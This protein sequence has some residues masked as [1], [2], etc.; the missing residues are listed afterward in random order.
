[1][2]GRGNPSIRMP[3]SCDDA[4][5]TH[6]WLVL[7]SVDRRDRMALSATI[8]APRW[9][10]KGSAQAELEP[11]DGSVRL[12]WL[13]LDA[14]TTHGLSRKYTCG[15]DRMLGQPGG[16]LPIELLHPWAR[17]FPTRSRDVVVLLGAGQ[18]AAVR[19]YGPAIRRQQAKRDVPGVE[20]APTL[21]ALGHRT[22]HA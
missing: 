8:P 17:E 6:L 20:M 21:P 4:S 3:E 2:R 5:R 19:Q 1:M 7:S 13:S 22:S 10:C 18:N 11:E 12:R 14:S 15:A 9:E 16:Q